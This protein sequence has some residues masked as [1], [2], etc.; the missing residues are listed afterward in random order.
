MSYKPTW[1]GGAI[2]EHA[3]AL[4]MRRPP[5]RMA[6][7]MRQL[8]VIEALAPSFVVLTDPGFHA[9]TIFSIKNRHVA[10]PV[11]YWSQHPS[12]DHR[13]VVVLCD[14]LLFLTSAQ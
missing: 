5:A 4:M 9:L 10:T 14:D 13:R 3:A 12:E 11:T 8:R 1:S 7:K 2:S 6:P